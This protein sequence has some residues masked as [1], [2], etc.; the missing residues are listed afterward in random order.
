MHSRKQG[1]GAGTI[2][3][4][5]IMLAGALMLFFPNNEGGA[6]D[7]KGGPDAPP[8]FI[9]ARDHAVAWLE[10]QMVPNKSLPRSQPGR[11]GMIM[12]FGVP[13]GHVLFGKSSLYDNALAIIALDM[14][15]HTDSASRIAAAVC[16]QMDASPE[17]WFFYNLH[18]AW[19]EPEN[20]EAVART[21]ASAWLGCALVFHCQVL[22]MEDC[23]AGGAEYAHFIKYA[24]RLAGMLIKR[25]IRDAEDRRYGLLP[26]GMNSIVLSWDPGTKSP[27]ETFKRMEIDWVSTEHSIDTWFFLNGLAVLTGKD[28]Y[29][30]DAGLVRAGIMKRLWNE[31]IGQFNTGMTRW[32]TDPAESLDCASW[33]SLF[34]HATG[35]R[36]MALTA[37]KTCANYLNRHG[38]VSGYRPYNNA[39]IYDTP[40]LNAK[41]FPG[42]PERRWNDLP[43]VWPEGSLGVALASFRNNQV[44]QGAEILDNIIKMQLPDGGIPYASEEVPN[45]FT[46]RTAVASAAWLVIAVNARANPE[47]DALF[48]R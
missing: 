37:L 39:M 43:F 14:A 8:R 36:E 27:R 48:W 23:A 13:E 11:E 38:A 21:G 26:G 41:M 34:L 45:L 44:E 10:G 32:E 19:P 40:A 31:G 15:G 4:A 22:L 6:Q 35:Q 16:S 7:L 24:K 46:K 25:Q 12:S 20:P 18:N 30:Q 1:D 42:D 9:A 17:P 28:R 3:G 29:R 47:L 5:C 33:G 2:P